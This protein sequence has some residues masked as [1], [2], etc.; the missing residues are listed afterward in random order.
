MTPCQEKEVSTAELAVGRKGSNKSTNPLQRSQKRKRKQPKRLP[1]TNAIYCTNF[2]GMTKNLTESIEDMLNV[3]KMPYK[4][5]SLQ[6]S[7]MESTFNKLIQLTVLQ[8]KQER[9]QHKVHMSE[10]HDSF[11]MLLLRQSMVFSK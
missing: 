9:R 8:H 3:E 5:S 11:M 1:Q 2:S 10:M 4:P 6:P 7:A